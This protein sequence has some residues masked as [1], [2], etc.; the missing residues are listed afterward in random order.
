MTFSSKPGGHCREPSRLFSARIRYAPTQL[1]RRRWV[2]CGWPC[3]QGGLQRLQCPSVRIPS[4]RFAS[5]FYQGGSKDHGAFQK[6]VL[7]QSEGVIALPDALSFEE[8][9]VLP[10]AVLTALSSWTT[11]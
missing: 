3:R 6:Y 4:D 8:G 9:A 11:T 10:L 7:A 2:R 1:S 5:S